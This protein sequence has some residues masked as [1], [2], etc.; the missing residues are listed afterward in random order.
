MALNVKTTPSQG[1][2]LAAGATETAPRCDSHNDHAIT[3]CAN[4]TGGERSSPLSDAYVRILTSLDNSKLSGDSDN[5]PSLVSKGSER[6]IHSTGYLPIWSKQ[7][8]IQWGTVVFH[9]P[10]PVFPCPLML[11]FGQFMG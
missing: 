3:E 6:Y 2:S 9:S 5:Q 1:D 4:T 11:N 8:Y 7:H 10:C